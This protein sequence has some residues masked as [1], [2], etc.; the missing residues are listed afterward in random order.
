MN[1]IFS[2]IATILQSESF[3][4]KFLNWSS[5]IADLILECK[6]S[7]KLICIY[8]NGGSAADS[9]HWAAEL[10]CTYKDRLRSAFP[11]IALTTDTSVLTAWSNDFD[12]STV[13]QRQVDALG[14]IIGMS[15][16]IST[17][18]TS[19]N[20][21]LALNKSLELGSK[22]V[23]ISG[24]AT[25]NNIAYDMHVRF[26]SSD[27]PIVQTLTQMLYHEVCQNLEER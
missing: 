19:K 1:D 25:P 18:G 23:L 4:A 26:P 17:S 10:T 16:G 8:G 15:I 5:Y 11:A 9:Q 24:S 6:Q 22:T 21:L 27:T 12:F 2:S 13:Y 14:I 7:N 20:V 3:N